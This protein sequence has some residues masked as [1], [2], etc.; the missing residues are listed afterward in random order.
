MNTT[1]LGSLGALS[2]SS[3]AS[4]PLTVKFL[5]LARYTEPVTAPLLRPLTYYDQYTLARC[6]ACAQGIMTGLI[7]HAPSVIAQ[8]VSALQDSVADEAANVCHL[9]LIENDNAGGSA[10]TL[11]DVAALNDMVGQVVGRLGALGASTKDT[12]KELL[13]PTLAAINKHIGTMAVRI[14]LKMTLDYALFTL[15][16]LAV[17]RMGKL[18]Q[19][20]KSAKS[21]ASAVETIFMLAKLLNIANVVLPLLYRT[22]GVVKAY[23]NQ[24]A[25]AE[26]IREAFQAL[27]PDQ[28]PDKQKLITFIETLLLAT[29]QVSPSTACTIEQVLDD[30]QQL[31]E[32]VASIQASNELMGLVRIMKIAGAAKSKEAALVQPVSVSGEFNIPLGGL[33]C[34]RNR[35]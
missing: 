11:L 15:A 21:I 17:A 13:K 14:L 19:W 7:K 27:L 5:K 3:F 18:V 6:Q 30:P 26:R 25:R 4:H 12:I 16:H 9:N 20:H 2:K 35:T 22:V 34:L 24:S 33:S 8:K 23:L 28:V 29:S 10:G 32:L 1:I 31:Q